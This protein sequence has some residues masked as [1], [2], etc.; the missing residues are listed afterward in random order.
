MR[1]IAD[2]DI[3]LDSGDFSLMDRRVVDTL[4]HMPERN[5]FVRGLRAW[6]GFRQTGVEYDRGARVAGESKYSIGRLAT[7]ALDGLISYSFVPLRLV[8]LTGIFV[9]LCSL[10]GMGYLVVSHLIDH[11][12]PQGWTSLIVTMLFLGGIQ[13]LALGILGE[14]LGRM[15][16]EVKQRPLFV[17]RELLGLAEKA[18][19]GSVEALPGGGRP[20]TV[21][22][23]QSGP[24]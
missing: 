14:Y 3:P 8:S 9:S 6:V 4:N 13:L 5:R 24:Q 11:E 12:A 1:F 22:G 15:F 19:S 18:S 16:E 20:L 23:G 2:I 10:T 17:A 21:N 7:L